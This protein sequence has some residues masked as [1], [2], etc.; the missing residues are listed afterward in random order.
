VDGHVATAVEQ[1]L[2]QHVRHDLAAGEDRRI[3]AVV[4]DLDE[5]V[6]LVDASGY[7]VLGDLSG[8]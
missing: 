1:R 7:E 5:L 8:L 2:T 4:A 3:T 6:P